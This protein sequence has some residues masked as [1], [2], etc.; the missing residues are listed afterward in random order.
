MNPAEGSRLAERLAA[1]VPAIV[2]AW[3]VAVRADPAIRSDDSISYAAFVDH[4]PH[5]IQKICS[6]LRD[7]VFEDERDAIQ[8]EAR[9]HGVFRWRQ[10]YDLA[11]V[12][13]EIGHLRQVLMAAAAEAADELDVPE[14]DR[15][16][17]ERGILR[18]IDEGQIATI[19][20][21][22]GERDREA[23][24][25]DREIAA[26]DRE[27]TER[28]RRFQQALLNQERSRSEALESAA[29]AKDD[30]LATLSHELR[31]PLTPI[32]AWIT[33]LEKDRS[34]ATVDAAVQTLGRNARVLA[35]L[36]EDLLDVSRIVAGKLEL[37]RERL[38]GRDVLRAA[39]ETVLP[40]AGVRGVSLIL[41]EAAEPLPLLGDAMRLQQVVWNLL[42]NAVKFSRPAGEVRIEA[43]TEGPEIVISVSDD[44]IGI[45]PE[46]LPH[47]FERF[48]QQDGRPA[49]GR[50]GLGL[51]LA[52]ARSIA[53]AHGGRLTAHS[54]GEGRGSRFELRLPAAGALVLES[55]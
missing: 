25:R 53:E 26:R 8:R 9:T 2:D 34:R 6:V 52:I 19:L 46:F 30:F 51:G 3:S 47:I 33:I 29:V 18:V 41:P 5:V 48:R 32:L 21:Y 24:E 54:E 4:I 50:G 49:R 28:E 42:S 12:M 36:I 13:R 37:V 11:E 15:R 35:Q 20:T 17:L 31:T 23:V 44:G 1:N 14:T 40:A 45:A 7:G 55:A 16:A 27:I 39:R 22:V 10:G 43:T 38:D